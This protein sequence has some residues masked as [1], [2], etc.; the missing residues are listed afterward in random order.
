MTILVKD[1][2]TGQ[3]LIRD[4]DGTIYAAAIDPERIAR[5]RALL[6]GEWHPYV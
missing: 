4:D 1:V 6:R 2:T 5:I 3:M